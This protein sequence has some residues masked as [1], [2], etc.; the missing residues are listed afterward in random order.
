MIVGAGMAG[1]T[2]AN[3][4]HHA[5]I[6]AVV[7][8]ARDRIGGRLHT[9]DVGGSPVDLGGSWIHTPIG[10]PMSAW[11]DQVGVERRPANV[12][13]GRRRLGRDARLVDR[14]R[15]GPILGEGWE[16]PAA[17]EAIGATLSPGRVRRRRAG[18]VSSRA[19]R[20]PGQSSSGC[21]PSSARRSN[22]TVPR[23]PTRM[24]AAGSVSSTLEYEGDYVGDM[25]LGGYGRAR[26][27]DGCR[28]RHPPRL[29]RRDR[30]RAACRRHR[31]EPGRSHRDRQS[32]PRDPAARRPAGRIGPVR[33]GPCLPSGGPSW[34]A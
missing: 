27:G 10:N 12:L 34:I 15:F 26:R 32:R 16:S 14:E 13:V 20:R 18:R 7:L 11:A 4:L 1:L 9:A 8:E 30:S 2:A 29:G 19:R 33:A 22:R 24:S 5:G 25:P 23:R 21:E 6:P 31:L 17:L 28:A 3:A